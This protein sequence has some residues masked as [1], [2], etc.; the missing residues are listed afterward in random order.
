MKQAR[1]GGFAQH[2]RPASSG[3]WLHPLSSRDRRCSALRGLR[4]GRLASSPCHGRRNA[5]VAYALPLAVVP[6]LWHAPRRTFVN[7]GLTVS[8]VLGSGL[9]GLILN[10]AAVSG[11]G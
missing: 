8:V 2:R 9:A 5:N 3:F 10:K 11:I 4:L 7:L 1:R 6:R